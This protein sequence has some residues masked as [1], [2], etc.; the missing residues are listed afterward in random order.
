MSKKYSLGFLI[1]VLVLTGCSKAKFHSVAP[2]N[3]IEQPS[4]SATVNLV[5]SA[6]LNN[7][8]A[9][10]IQS[11]SSVPMIVQTA[12]NSSAANTTTA[13]NAAAPSTASE[14]VSESASTCDLWKRGLYG[15]TEASQRH[16]LP[17]T[18]FLNGPEFATSTIQ[19][20]LSKDSNN[21]INQSEMTSFSKLT[22]AVNINDR[23]YINLQ[24]VSCDRRITYIPFHFSSQFDSTGL[25]EDFSGASSIVAGAIKIGP[26]D[27][28]KLYYELMSKFGKQGLELISSGTLV[29]DKFFGS[30]LVANQSLST[31]MD[32][33]LGVYN[34]NFLANYI[35]AKFPK[36]FTEGQIEKIMTSTDINTF[37]LYRQSFY[38][39][40]SSQ[41]LRI[42]NLMFQTIERLRFI[43]GSQYEIYR[44][45]N[46]QALG[47]STAGESSIHFMS[48]IE[49]AIRWG[50]NNYRPNPNE[51]LPNESALTR[52]AAELSRRSIGTCHSSFSQYPSE[53][54]LQEAISSF[55]LRDMSNDSC[56]YLVLSS[57]I[58][59]RNNLIP[60]M[61]EMFKTK[62]FSQGEGFIY[63]TEYA[64]RRLDL[65][66][67]CEYG[68]WKVDPVLTKCSDY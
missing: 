27:T 1:S 41:L 40:N 25:V 8:P 62:N 28:V 9:T 26:Y 24:L 12:V 53:A 11:S 50:L 38:S 4:Q 67:V 15:A 66:M 2:E 13:L 55:D 21:N 23:R 43:F 34:N 37:V 5:S 45:G 29:S 18:V 51:I 16:I 3:Q 68:Y 58:S 48:T 14:S 61:W 10:G 56:G 17:T 59:A 44:T 36:E 19:V 39:L 35:M 20:Q 33:D 47:M 32:L 22:W 30:A 57:Q 52:L 64:Q 7:Q 60:Y 6:E 31:L 46:F 63:Q 42:E 54:K 65:A 49:T